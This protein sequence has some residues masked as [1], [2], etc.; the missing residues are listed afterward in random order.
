MTTKPLDIKKFQYISSW[1]EATFAIDDEGILY[2]IDTE[3]GAIRIARSTVLDYIIEA[4][5]GLSTRWD[6]DQVVEEAPMK[7]EDD[8]GEA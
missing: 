1:G 4:L 5:Q 3:N 6:A 8:D 7:E 2:F